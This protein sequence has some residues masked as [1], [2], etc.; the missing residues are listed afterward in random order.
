MVYYARRRK[1]GGGVS[2]YYYL[3]DLSSGCYTVINRRTAKRPYKWARRLVRACH[4][5][6]SEEDSQHY[7]VAV[8]EATDLDGWRS[9]RVVRTVAIRLA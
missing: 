8:V 7:P 1:K 2:T 5:L 3:V 4:G 6:P 9:M